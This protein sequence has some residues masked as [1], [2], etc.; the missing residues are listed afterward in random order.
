M[1]RGTR[2]DEQ[3]DG[4]GL[5]LSIVAKMVERYGGS[6]RLNPSAMGGLTV[7]LRIPQSH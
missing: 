4:H 1:R 2:L 5:G 3:T 6:I 7:S